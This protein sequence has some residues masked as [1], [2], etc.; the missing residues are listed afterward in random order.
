[1]LIAGARDLDPVRGLTHCFYK[2]PARFSP[3]FV[4]AAIDVFTSPGDVVMDNRVGGG[5]TAVEAIAAGRHAVRVDISAL[6]EFVSSVK[7]THSA[8]RAPVP[9][10]GG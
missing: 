5:T 6:S 2:Y 8:K 1:M 3:A 7:T 9:G 10:E 4:R